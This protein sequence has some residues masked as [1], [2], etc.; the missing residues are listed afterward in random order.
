[1][2]VNVFIVNSHNNSR[3]GDMNICMMVRDVQV[4]GCQTIDD[5]A[6]LA[7]TV[8]PDLVF[9]RLHPTDSDPCQAVKQIT[10]T[11]QKATI[12]ISSY[13][14]SINKDFE[15]A[16]KQ[17]GVSSFL[18]EDITGDKLL[19]FIKNFVD[20][21]VASKHKKDKTKVSDIFEEKF[22]I[23]ITEVTGYNDVL[24][25]NKQVGA[26]KLKHDL[27][28]NLTYI[29]IFSFLYDFLVKCF[30]A[31]IKITVALLADNHRIMIFFPWDSESDKILKTAVFYSV[32]KDYIS[33]DNDFYK[34][35]IPLE[36]NIKDSEFCDNTASIPTEY[37]CDEIFEKALNNTAYGMS[38]ITS[39]LNASVYYENFMKI[40]VFLSSFI[41]NNT[42]TI[43]LEFHR[44]VLE[45][46]VKNIDNAIA[47]LLKYK[48]QENSRI[49]IINYENMLYES[50]LKFKLLLH[51]CR[52]R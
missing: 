45:V 32:S 40:F 50:V 31:D 12:A 42:P 23:F 14:V 4:Y 43:E 33:S 29:R 51:I 48:A 26:L 7:K 35:Y 22:Y 15:E 16:C 2:G 24:S 44:D 19:Y 47:A 5:A 25:M 11:H 34:I 6:N 9:L 3:T 27:P 30:L 39:L 17:S 46:I 38:D 37:H 49:D 13:N 10:Q 1:M 36:E 28:H 52:H 21:T 8:R 18:Y 41:K 20:I